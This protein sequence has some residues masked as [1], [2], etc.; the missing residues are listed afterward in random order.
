M[1]TI[2]KSNAIESRPRVIFN[3][4]EE[5]TDW[6]IEPKMYIK[7]FHDFIFILGQMKLDANR[8]TIKTLRRAFGEIS[9]KWGS[10]CIVEAKPKI[11]SIPTNL[12]CDHN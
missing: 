10:P 9:D 5:N 4:M 8:S 6:V 1:S 2:S 7:L 11:I 12:S 3:S